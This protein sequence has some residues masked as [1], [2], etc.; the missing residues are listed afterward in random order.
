MRLG[1]LAAR[2]FLNCS[3]KSEKSSAANLTSSAAAEEFLD[4]SQAF[5]DFSGCSSDI[6]GELQRLECLPSPK[7]GGEEELQPES[8]F[9]FLQRE[10]F[11]TEIIESISPEDLQPTVKIC[12][13]DRDGWLWF[14]FLLF[15]VPFFFFYFSF[16]FL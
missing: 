1:E 5:S 6:S 3:G 11:S 15:F 16:L 14:F 9:G 7:R 8:C 10:S 4:I 12:V 2:N 13:E